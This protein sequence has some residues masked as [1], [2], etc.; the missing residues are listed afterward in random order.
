[1]DE[2]LS[3]LKEYIEARSPEW[4]SLDL[5][6]DEFDISN[7]TARRKLDKLVK[8]GTMRVRPGDQDVSRTYR[9]VE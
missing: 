7:S 6:E 1:V 8:K 4:V 5:V 9:W 2:L 3:D